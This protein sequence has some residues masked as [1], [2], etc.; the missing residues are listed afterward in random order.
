MLVL[1]GSDEHVQPFSSGDCAA[2]LS[3]CAPWQCPRSALEGAPAG[4]GRCRHSQRER[5][6]GSLV[7]QPPPRKASS[8]TKLCPTNTKLC[9]TDFTA[10]AHSGADFAPYLLDLQTFRWRRGGGGDGDY[11]GEGEGEG[12]DG[13]RSP[14]NPYPNPNPNPNPNSHPNP[15]PSPDLYPNQERTATHSPTTPHSPRP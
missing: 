12:E 6:A 11:E 1:G 3:R 15:N 14:T 7:A 2:V 4:S 8:I 9:P 10:F 5:Q 13:T